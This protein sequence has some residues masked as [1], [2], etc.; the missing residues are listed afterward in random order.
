MSEAVTIER[1]KARAKYSRLKSASLLPSY[2]LRES[3]LLSNEGITHLYSLPWASS[4]GHFS[5][6]TA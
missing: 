3:L 5:L 2:T 6:R 4:S 1:L